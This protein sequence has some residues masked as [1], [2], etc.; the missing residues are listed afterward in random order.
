MQVSGRARLG[1]G[2]ENLIELVENPSARRVPRRTGL[3]HIAILVPS[4]FALAQ[5]L[6]RI[7]ETRTPVTGFADHHVSEAIYLPD[8][9]GN[10]IE[11][12]QDRPRDQWE[13]PGGALK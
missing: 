10:G 9:D 11:I 4:R 3:Y 8:P 13:F 7:A 5:S 2:E 1:A 6:A 12:Y